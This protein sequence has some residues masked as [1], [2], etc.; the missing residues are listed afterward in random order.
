MP[1]CPASVASTVV[2][3]W[4]EPKT[5]PISSWATSSTTNV[6]VTSRAPVTTAARCVWASRAVGCSAN[7]QPKTSRMPAATT[8]A[9]SGLAATTMRPSR[10]GPSTKEASSAAPS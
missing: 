4:I 8:S 6:T 2:P 9:S 1:A 7:A 10:A 5:T 3:V